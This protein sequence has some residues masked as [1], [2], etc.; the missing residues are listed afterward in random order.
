M[1]EIPD[2][3]SRSKVDIQKLIDFGFQKN[4]SNYTYTVDLIE[5]QFTM[6]VT[7]TPQG[8]VSTT[9][10]DKPTG[11]DYVLH[12]VAAATGSFLATIRAQ[13]DKVLL[14]IAHKCFVPDVFKCHITRQVIQY[15]KNKYG[16]ELEFLWP[17]F[18]D[19]AIFRRKDNAKWYGAILTVENQKLG[20]KGNDRIEILDLRMHPD[21]IT[22]LVDGEKYFPGFHMNKKHWITLRLDGSVP[23]EEIFMRID[24]SFILADK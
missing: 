13:H 4:E 8:E 24:E 22:Q 15:I 1:K 16:D 7:V 21:N 9:V 23:V 18:P 12:R 19:N 14:E 17:R 11:E 6:T 10:V 3:F 2:L 5:N 20:L